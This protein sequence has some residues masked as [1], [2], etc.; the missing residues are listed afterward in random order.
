M[1]PPTLRLSGCGQCCRALAFDLAGYPRKP[2]DDASRRRMDLGFRF[3]ALVVKRLQDEGFTIADQQR[4]VRVEGVTGHIDGTMAREDVPLRL[5]EVKSM[6]ASSWRDWRANGLRFARAPYVRA[7][8]DQVQAYMQGLRS[9]GIPVD[10]C[11]LVVAFRD[12]SDDPCG[13]DFEVERETLA[14]DEERVEAVR[15]RLVR[16]MAGGVMG[17]V[18]DESLREHGLDDAGFIAAACKWCDHNVPCWGPLLPVKIGRGE[19][20]MPASETEF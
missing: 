20:L 17:K 5:L 1:K 11:Q 6:G 2:F 16:A 9:D 3:E 15:S 10:S 13:R 8:Y 14:F 19:R 4:V 12:D 7:Y 18:P